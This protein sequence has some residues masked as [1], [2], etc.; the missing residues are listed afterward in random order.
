MIKAVLWDFGGVLTTSPFEAFARFEMERGLPADFIRRVN[1]TNPDSNAWAKF[2]RS[3]V[4]LDE[5]DKLF[6]GESGELGHPIRGTEIIKLLAGDIRPNMVNALKLCGEKYICTC[7]TNNVAAGNGPGMTRDAA[8]QAEV[9]AVMGLFQQVIESSKIGLRKPDPRIY[10]YACE[11]MGVK[12]EEVVY[13]DDLGI[14]LKPA[15]AM[16]MKTIKVVNEEQ[17]LR[18]LATASNLSFS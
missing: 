13:L 9:E 1:S 10:E 12:P 4:T 14:N 8:A 7:L 3:A 2:E 17:A 6:E 16:G 11:Q 15:A 18:D 5:F